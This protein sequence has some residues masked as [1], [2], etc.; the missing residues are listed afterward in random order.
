MK[1][2]FYLIICFVVLYSSCI[3]NSNVYVSRLDSTLLFI[4]FHK[5]QITSYE[6]PR[7]RNKYSTDSLYKKFELLD[8]TANVLSR[9]R[10]SS[11]SSAD[12][13]LFFGSNY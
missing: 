8:F 3:D 2:L 6:L 5:S 1:Y 10:F 9:I 12:S 4:E 11:A 7:S 13:L